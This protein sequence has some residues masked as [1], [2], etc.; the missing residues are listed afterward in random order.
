M[1]LVST[2]LTATGTTLC[3]AVGSTNSAGVLQTGAM[4]LR[5]LSTTQS[6]LANGNY[7]A[8]ATSLNT[9]QVNCT[10]NPSAPACSQTDSQGRLLASLSGSV[11]R[12]SGNFPENFIRAN[13]QVNNAVMETN[14]GHSNYHSLQTQV[15]LRPTAGVSTQLTYT[16]SRNL[17]Q[18]PP[19]G[20]NGAG[21][22]FTEPFNRAAD[23]TLL[24]THR[25]HVVVNYGTF[26]LPIGPSKLLFANSSG[27]WAR[28]AENWQA[29]WVVNLSSGAP[30]N[31]SA[32]SLYAT[33]G[34]IGVPDVVGPFDRNISY[35]WAEGAAN[36][37]LFTDS[38]GRPLYTRG[39]DPQCTNTA[40]VAPNLASACT[41]NAISN[42]SGQVVLQNPLP[43]KRGTLGQNAVYGLGTWTADMAIQKRVQFAESRSFTVRVDAQNMFN[44]PNPGLVPGLFAAT[45]GAPDLNVQ[46]ATVPFG[47]FT[48]KLGNRTFQLKAR[49]DF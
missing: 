48:N 25:K 10:F 47:A 40:Y 21:A 34:T 1:S 37:N 28:L 22:N 4:H 45:A 9:L 20:P 33:A 43:G 27:L 38:N 49:V 15:S 44:H 35:S 39:R 8:L 16:W 24:S 18:A 7:V 3:G 23:Y 32:N 26:D 2:C 11:L 12:N 6:N 42:S 30:G 31:I 14:L 41:L 19:E 29:S 17:G 36:G 46:T 13:P 5:S